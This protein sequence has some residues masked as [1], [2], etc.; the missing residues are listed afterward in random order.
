MDND[1][2]DSMDECKC[3]VVAILQRLGR[4][5]PTAVENGVRGRYARRGRRV[6]ASHDPGQNVDRG[7]GVAT[8]ERA[9]FDNSSF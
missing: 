4:F 3:C 6:L 9:Y 8:R 5:A 2:L 1:T 7:P